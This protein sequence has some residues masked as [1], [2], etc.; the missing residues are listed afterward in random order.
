MIRIIHIQ[1]NTKLNLL[2]DN[3]A[4]TETITQI[5]RKYLMNKTKR[6]LVDHILQQN[7]LGEILY[8]DNK[9]FLDLVAKKFGFKEFP[10]KYSTGQKV[11]AKSQD[12]A[13]TLQLGQSLYH[14][15]KLELEK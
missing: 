2:E 6:D 15:V 5:T 4:V 10:I 7:E 11:W 14:F 13:D 1:F 8:R 3:M 9:Y 12:Q